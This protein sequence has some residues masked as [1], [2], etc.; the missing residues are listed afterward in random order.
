MG[1]TYGI[2]KMQHL[3]WPFLKGGL[4]FQ[5]ELVEKVRD[6]D[7]LQQR[8]EFFKKIF[9]GDPFRVQVCSLRSF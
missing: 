1:K 8:C 7:M 2:L 4:T 6:V 5:T 3:S 9:A